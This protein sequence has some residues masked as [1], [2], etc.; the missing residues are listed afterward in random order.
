MNLPRLIL[1]KSSHLF[2]K[3]K[4]HTFPKKIE[5]VSKE[6][7]SAER[8]HFFLRAPSTTLYFHPV[9]VTT[10]SRSGHTNTRTPPVTGGE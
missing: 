7:K 3:T 5:R 4:I 2:N 9:H 6:T 10:G 8:D 1:P